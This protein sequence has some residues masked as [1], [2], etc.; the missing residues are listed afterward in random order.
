MRKERNR[1]RLQKERNQPP[2]KKIKT[3]DTESVSIRE[4]WGRPPPS[5][6]SKNKNGS[7]KNQRQ[8]RER[9]NQEKD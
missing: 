9:L 5:A 7:K 8:R 2:K 1:M 6:P 4:I 3:D